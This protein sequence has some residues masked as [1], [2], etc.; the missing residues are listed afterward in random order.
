MIYIVLDLDEL[1][2]ISKIDK[3][4]IFHFY[5]NKYRIL[6]SLAPPPLTKDFSKNR[7]GQDYAKSEFYIFL[8]KSKYYFNIK[9]I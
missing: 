1:I 8:E 4:I 9:Y 2:K 3:K 6:H 7:G 5:Q